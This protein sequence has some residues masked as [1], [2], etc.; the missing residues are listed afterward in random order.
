MERI[1]AEASVESPHSH[2][3][4]HGSM[5]S[6]S[7]SFGKRSKQASFVHKGKDNNRH[8]KHNKHNQKLRPFV[9]QANETFFV[10]LEFSTLALGLR[11]EGYYR[12]GDVCRNDGPSTKEKLIAWGPNF[13]VQGCLNKCTKAECDGF[14]VGFLPDSSSMCIMYFSPVS[15]VVSYSMAGPDE[16]SDQHAPVVAPGPGDP[17]AVMPPKRS[18]GC[19][20]DM[21]MYTDSPTMSPTQSPTWSTGAKISKAT[22]GIGLINAIVSDAGV[23]TA[24]VTAN[25]PQVNGELLMVLR[26]LVFTPGVKPAI[27]ASPKLL[28]SLAAIGIHLY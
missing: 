11:R 3:F 27:K 20:S 1:E 15:E 25:D 2:A 5:H 13:M 28:E 4:P 19:Y 22:H 12:I 21:P 24:L 9:S 17:N 6:S 14:E 26:T 8:N 7:T 10:D 23:N 18:L 16:P